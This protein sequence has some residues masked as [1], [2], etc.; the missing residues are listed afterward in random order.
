MRSLC[1]VLT[2]LFS[3]G[4]A[5]PGD[6]GADE[7]GS[8]RETRIE[9]GSV[10]LGIDARSRERLDEVLA[11]R[12]APLKKRYPARNPEATLT[13][14]GIEPG[15]TVVEAL[16][17][18]GW[19]TKILLPYLGSRGRLIGANYPLDMWPNFPFATNEFMGQIARWLDRFRAEAERWC[20]GDC[21]DVDAFW[22][23]ELPEAM[24][25]SA[26]AMLFIRALHDLARFQKAGKGDFLDR[27]LGDA[28]A[29]VAPGGILGIV[30]DQARPG[31]PDA[32][33]DGSSGYLRQRFVIERVEAAGFVFVAESD[34]NA[35][36]ADRA[37]VE[38]F[39]WRLPPTLR[40]DTDPGLECD[41]ASFD[42][43]HRMTL[44]FRKPLDR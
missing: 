3:V 43:A 31:T 13:F 21:A 42:D 27:A 5:D 18:E 9:T 34:I 44:R 7:S 36:P 25:G 14:F 1:I 28:F 39:V 6:N 41:Y 37:N 29:V 24:H 35:N 8:G 16:P 23:G 17:R 30:Q 19:Y 4:C 2:L 15:M 40:T 38:N 22:L 32:L 20:T 26:D 33:A 12:P 10:P 11:S